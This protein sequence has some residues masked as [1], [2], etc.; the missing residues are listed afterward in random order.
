MEYRKVSEIPRWNASG[1]ERL[2]KLAEFLEQLHANRLSFANWRTCAVG[3]AAKDPWFRAQGLALQH[4]DRVGECRPDYAGRTDWMAVSK[5]FEISVGEARQLL[6]RSGYDGDLRPP[7]G[8][9]A[10]KI[11]CYLAA[12]VAA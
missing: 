1:Q 6:D 8:T 10:E 3:L 4:D 9:I 11:R 12:A 5:F 2:K 7:P